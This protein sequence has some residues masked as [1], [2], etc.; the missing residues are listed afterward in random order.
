MY[1]LSMIVICPIVILLLLIAVAHFLLV[2]SSYSV[3]NVMSIISGLL[4]IISL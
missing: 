4:I 1:L 3:Y 2:C